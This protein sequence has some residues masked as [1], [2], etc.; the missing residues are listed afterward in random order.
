VIPK[1]PTMRPILIALCFQLAAPA[2]GAAAKDAPPKGGAAAK[3]TPPKDAPAKTETPDDADLATAGKVIEIDGS[4]NAKVVK[5][6][7]TEP[8]EPKPED[9]PAPKPKEEK[10]KATEI[11]NAEACKLRFTAQCSW[12]KRCLKGAG[13][14]PM[15][16]DE[17][18]A[19]CDSAAPGKAA[20]ARKPVEACA[21][22][23]T[24]L[25]C[26]KIDLNNPASLNPEAQVP[27]CKPLLDAD[28]AE[29][30]KAGPGSG[31]GTELPKDID[32][33]RALRGE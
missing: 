32:I 13:D 31:G 7:A 19:A 9:K 27:A 4:G 25:K 22:G 20:Y 28:K 33:G 5:G 18:I 17:L 21:K 6:E 11:S 24:A 29:L 12:L 1:E 26:E 8:A 2:L 30:E 14:L 15:P 3:K 16:C 23:V 10:L